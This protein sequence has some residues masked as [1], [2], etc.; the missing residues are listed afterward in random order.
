[1]APRL[2][3]LVPLEAGHLARI[4]EHFEIHHAERANLETIATL[5]PGVR[6]VWTNGSIG[7]S[8]A[9]LE[10]L[11]DVEMVVAQG[12]GYENIAMDAARRRG[13]VVSNG[14]GT[15]AACVADHAMALLLASVRE[16]PQVDQAARQGGWAE[17]RVSRPA[18]YGKRLGIVGLG[19]AGSQL[20]RRAGGFDMTVSY[21]NRRPA[22][23]VPYGY[24]PTVRELAAWADF[25]VLT[26]PGGPGTRHIVNAPVLEALGRSGYLVNV[27]RGSVV[28]TQALVEALRERRIA[29]AALDVFDDEPGI[30]APLKSLPNVV[31]TPHL[32]GSAPEVRDDQVELALRNFIAYFAG[33]PLVNILS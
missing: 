17:L 11:P 13:L 14:A 23:G 30:P 26:C 2:L 5:G 12:A 25:L 21:H 24:F 15:N 22:E 28:D 27:A 8:S 16:I 20:A 32:A 3:V 1:V 7:L 6:G 18:L 10:A 29:G 19:Q 9:A 33:Q 31:L 4:R